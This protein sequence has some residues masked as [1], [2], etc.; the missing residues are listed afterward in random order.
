MEF[1]EV[2]SLDRG[3]MATIRHTGLKAPNPF[4]QHSSAREQSECEMRLCVYMSPR[5]F[6]CN[7]SVT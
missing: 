4:H 3:H 6:P 7:F 5:F 2:K 1:K